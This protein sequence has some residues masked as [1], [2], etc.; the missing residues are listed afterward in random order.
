MSVA[1][2]STGKAQ[3]CRNELFALFGIWVG[4]V[5]KS[6][7]KQARE[8]A[9]KALRGEARKL[10][11]GELLKRGV[12]VAYQR[13]ANGTQSVTVS[14]DS[15]KM[16]REVKDDGRSAA[17][18]S[19]VALLR[20]RVESQMTHATAWPIPDRPQTDPRNGGGALPLAH[21]GAADVDYAALHAQMMYAHSS[22]VH[23]PA[24]SAKS[25]SSVAGGKVC[26]VT[27]ALLQHGGVARGAMH[28]AEIQDQGPVVQVHD[29]GPEVQVHDQGPEVQVQDPGPEVQVQDPGPKVQDQGPEVQVHD[30][31]PEVQVQDPGPEVQV[32][33]PG[34]KVQDQ[35]PE[36]QDQGPGSVALLF[37]TEEDVR[38]G[39]VWEQ[40]LLGAPPKSYTLYVHAQHPA[41]VMNPLF[42][43]SLVNEPV[44]QGGQASSSGPGATSTHPVMRLL[45]EA[46][47]EPSNRW[48]MVLNDACLPMVGF[49]T[50][51]TRMALHRKTSVF[52]F[53]PQKVQTE[54]LS[55]LKFVTNVPPLVRDAIDNADLVAHSLIGTMLVRRD[56]EVVGRAS[57]DVLRAWES[58][59]SSD[60][61]QDALFSPQGGQYFGH[62]MRQEETSDVDSFFVREQGA[63]PASLKRSL[64][65]SV[66][67]LWLF[68]LLRRLSRVEHGEA[69]AHNQ[70]SR[71]PKPAPGVC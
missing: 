33:D 38:N 25:K 18:N 8:E 52:D 58:A 23:R 57:S 4:W 69:C 22:G 36:V 11:V 12:A 70:V 14:W 34:P 20:K 54:M 49:D 29:Q 60:A 56:A 41:K 44:D 62:Y 42:K 10:Y 65:L 31:G 40:W 9:D 46:L 64:C 7:S 24:P 30:Q 16:E 66:A 67:E 2:E 59:L 27:N 37:A 48:F 63:A 26:K 43:D 61:V 5:D 35:G 45:Q 17:R 71:V 28:D 32:Q 13:F 19:F 3:T 21:P 50:F 47:K 39:A 1:S 68:A 6:L 53:H 15:L 55:V 51:F